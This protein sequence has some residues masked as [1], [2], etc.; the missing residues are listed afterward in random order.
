[1]RE[2][3]ESIVRLIVEHPGHIRLTELFGKQTLIFE[4]RC[5]ADDVGK[6]IGK[7]GKTIAAI[8]TIVSSAAQKDGKRAVVEIV[9]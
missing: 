4:L 2:L 8:R 9:E 1:M 7:S 3:I 5:H 6:V